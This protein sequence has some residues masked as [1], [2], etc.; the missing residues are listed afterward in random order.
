LNNLFEVQQ[1]LGFCND[2]RWFIA[3]YSEKAAPLTTLTNKNEPWLWEAEHQLAF[4]TMVT[5]FT[6][7]PALRHLDQERELIIE[8]EASDYVSA[9]VLSQRY[10]E[11]VL[12]PVAYYSKKH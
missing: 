8:S 7:A 1:F 9:P 5:A 6:T 10:D 3:K 12:H 2:Y 4:E 11:G